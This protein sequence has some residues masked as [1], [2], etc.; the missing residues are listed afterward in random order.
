MNNLIASS[1][2]D[3][4]VK[5]YDVVK[6]VPLA[7]FSEH[8]NVVYNVNWHPSMPNV[9]ASCSGDTTLKIWDTKMG[10]SILILGKSI[11]TV[12]AHPS[13][14]LS[15]DFNKYE[16]IIATSGSDGTI[17]IF[18]LRGTGDIPMLTL[19]GH[20]LST[21]KVAFSPFFGHILGSV[22]YDMNTMIWD[23][24]KNTYVNIFNHHKEFAIGID[25]SI[26]DNKRIATVGWDKA[27]W[28]FN[29]DENPNKMK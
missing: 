29:W 16:N 6:G 1:G 25:F 5:L 24:K 2:F 8:K 17:N 15:C 19:N 23:I 11:K 28:V 22:S 10:K 7:S 9:F 12:K 13:E 21:R 26:F 14:V 27:L 4:N 20:R 3:S 18:D